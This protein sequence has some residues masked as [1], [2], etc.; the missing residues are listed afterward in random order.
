MSSSASKNLIVE[1]TNLRKKNKKTRVILREAEN[2]CKTATLA[3]AERCNFVTAKK[4]C[5]IEVKPRLSPDICKEI[6]EFCSVSQKLI[7]GC[8]RKGWSLL[9][10]FLAHFSPSL[11]LMASDSIRRIVPAEGG[12]IHS[13]STFALYIYD[14]LVY[15]LRISLSLLF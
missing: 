15:S 11:S 5:F 6:T 14:N 12:H 7:D 8:G 13:G 9:I 1:F 10:S 2:C 3:L 4:K